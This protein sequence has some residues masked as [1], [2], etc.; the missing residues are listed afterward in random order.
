M[1]FASE[2]ET[3]ALRKRGRMFWKC[4]MRNYVSVRTESDDDMQ[5]PVSSHSLVDLTRLYL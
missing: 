1:E 5:N 4:R 2:D 3:E